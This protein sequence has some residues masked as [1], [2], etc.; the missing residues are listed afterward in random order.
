MWETSVQG[1]FYGSGALEM[2]PMKQRRVAN[3]GLLLG[4][5]CV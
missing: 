4:K 5:I 1:T 3:K 2:S